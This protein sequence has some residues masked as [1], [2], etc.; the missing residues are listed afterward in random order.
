MK[1]NSYHILENYEYS[2]TVKVFAKFISKLEHIVFICI[3]GSIAKE[4]C[5]KHS[6]LDI[7][8]K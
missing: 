1:K 8:G 6:D 5:Y 2:K 4:N 3:E 7:F